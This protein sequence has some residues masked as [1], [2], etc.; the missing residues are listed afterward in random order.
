MADRRAYVPAGGSSRLSID[1]LTIILQRSIVKL[2]IELRNEQLKEG[3]VP[4]L[5][6]P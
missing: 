5:L 2:E 6:T 3:L 1:A 4:Q